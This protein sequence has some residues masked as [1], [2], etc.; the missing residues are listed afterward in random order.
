MKNNAEKPTEINVKN[1]PITDT[2]K[3]KSIAKSTAL[4]QNPI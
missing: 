1:P 2:S 3:K 4:K